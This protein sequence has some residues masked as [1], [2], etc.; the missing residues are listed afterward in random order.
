[1]YMFIIITRGQYILQEPYLKFTV[2]LAEYLEPKFA[3]ICCT[4]A[5]SRP[6]Y[7]ASHVAYE[8]NPV[9]MLLS[10]QKKV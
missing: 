1:M 2:D 8:L 9:F 3:V 6:T 10:Y 5:L 4:V 7:K